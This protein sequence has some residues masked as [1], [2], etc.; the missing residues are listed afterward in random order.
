MDKLSIELK[1]HYYE[2]VGLLMDSIYNAEYD[3]LVDVTFE[4]VDYYLGL[5]KELEE[6]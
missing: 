2:M 3:N 5:I 4:A 6:C 1:S